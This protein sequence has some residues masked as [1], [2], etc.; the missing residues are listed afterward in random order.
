MDS[1]LTVLYEMHL[2]PQLEALDHDRKKVIKQYWLSLLVGVGFAVIIIPL[3][4]MY[5]LQAFGI[6]F[7]IIIAIVM[8]R[9]YS[10]RWD[11]S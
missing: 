10:K 8:H 1:K 5:E 3:S 2:K 6:I 4:F 9:L 11:R 7:A